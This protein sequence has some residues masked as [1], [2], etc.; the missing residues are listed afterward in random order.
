MRSFGII[1]CDNSWPALAG[2]SSMGSYGARMNG[3]MDAWDWY[4]VYMSDDD[5]FSEGGE[6]A[7]DLDAMLAQDELD[8]DELI[9]VAKHVQRALKRGM[10]PRRQGKILA[11]AAPRK[12]NRPARTLAPVRTKDSAFAEPEPSPPLALKPA[13]QTNRAPRVDV[14]PLA[15]EA[16]AA[17]PAP[18]P[19]TSH[20]ASADAAEPVAAAQA[21]AAST[22]A[23]EAAPAVSAAAATPATTEADTEVTADAASEVATEAASD[24]A[25]K[26][27]T[28]SDN[29]DK[30]IDELF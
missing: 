4:H 29:L 20:A 15:A 19:R 5:D 30:M 1:R 2:S 25:T 8:P 17:G 6:H 23:V 26:S 7:L 24:A 12:A 3:L 28:A 10:K 13:A 16:A 14:A 22:S 11:K 21:A 27:D 9:F 18:T